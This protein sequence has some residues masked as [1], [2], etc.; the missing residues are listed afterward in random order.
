MYAY[1]LDENQNCDY[2]SDVAFYVVP[3]EVSN[4]PSED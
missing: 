3:L 2:P 4:P 1:L